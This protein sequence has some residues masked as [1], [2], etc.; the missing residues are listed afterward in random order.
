MATLWRREEEF[1]SGPRRM[2]GGKEADIYFVL[3]GVDGKFI[4]LRNEILEALDGMKEAED[5]DD[6]E[7]DGDKGGNRKSKAD[8]GR[9]SK[10]DAGAQWG[11][12]HP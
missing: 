9:K 10:A 2:A 7:D 4:T 5:E 8:K 12:C 3:A 1:K 11:K 6:E